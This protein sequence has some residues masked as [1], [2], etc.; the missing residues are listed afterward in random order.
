MRTRTQEKVEK[1]EEYM[2]HHSLPANM[3]YMSVFLESLLG[4]ILCGARKIPLGATVAL[5]GLKGFFYTIFFRHQIQTTVHE[6]LTLSLKAQK[7]SV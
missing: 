5:F 7:S 2:A 6:R 4:S 1:V 3:R